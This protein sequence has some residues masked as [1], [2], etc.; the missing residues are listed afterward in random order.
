MEIS[1]D[2]TIS[3]A[4]A[5]QKVAHTLNVE[6]I[7]SPPQPSIGFRNAQCQHSGICQH[8]DDAKLVNPRDS[9]SPSWQDLY[10]ATG[11]LINHS[12]HRLNI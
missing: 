10:G 5:A 4:L 3:L 12:E 6:I 8:V 9:L 2:K 1:A 7:I 11:S